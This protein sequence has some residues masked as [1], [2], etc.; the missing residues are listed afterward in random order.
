ML[1]VVQILKTA[2]G[3]AA[4]APDLA[5]LNVSGPTRDQT[6]AKAHLAAEVLLGAYFAAHGK[7]PACRSLA[8]LRA[9]EPFRSA[10]LYEVYVEDHQL[11]AMAKHQTGK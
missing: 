2:S 6:L 1:A 8:E 3:F 11:T 7:L 4:T 10:E 5:A 9:T